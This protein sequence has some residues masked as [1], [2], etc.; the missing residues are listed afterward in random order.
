MPQRNTATFTRPKGEDMPGLIYRWRFFIALAIATIL[1]LSGCSKEALVAANRNLL[2]QYFEDNILNRD[3]VVELATDSTANLTSQ[4][5]GYT[6][7]LSKNTLQDGP[8]TASY[9]GTVI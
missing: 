6:F 8:M 7:K 3:F 9:G 1:L 5:N 4:F 2:E